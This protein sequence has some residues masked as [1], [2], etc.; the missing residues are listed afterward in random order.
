MLLSDLPG[1]AQ[2]A[3]AVLHSIAQA[4]GLVTIAPPDRPAAEEPAVVLPGAA[5][6]G[7]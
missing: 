1:V 6:A 7:L 3:R 4:K 2:A 5:E